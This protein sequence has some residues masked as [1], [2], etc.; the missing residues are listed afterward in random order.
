M[1]GYDIIILAG[2]SN[3]SGC[4]RGQTEWTPDS[5]IWLLNAP[6]EV[7]VEDGK[8]KTVFFDEPFEMSI[9]DERVTVDEGKVGGFYL[10]FA[11]AYK[12]SGRLEEGR[13]ILI[14]HSAI[15]GTGFLQGNWHEQGN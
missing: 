5:D 15:G 6:K 3:A 7:S 13:K 1:K 11:K 4:G 10:S 8:I 9:A 14:I 12:D 2:Q